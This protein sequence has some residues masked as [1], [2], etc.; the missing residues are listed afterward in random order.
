MFEK[1]GIK[2]FRILLA[3]GF[4]FVL[5]GIN[6]MIFSP[7]KKVEGFIS[8]LF[9]ILIVLSAGIIY[10]SILTKKSLLLYLGLNLFVYSICVS[11]IKCHD[12]DVTIL[13]VWPIMMISFGLTLIPCEYLKL[14]KIK[15][16]YIVPAIVLSVI[17]IVF[18]LFSFQVI[19]IPLA[20]F[21][22]IFWPVL[23]IVAGLILIV[24]YFYNSRTSEQSTDCLSE[25]VDE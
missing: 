23:M 3:I 8:I 15:T 25:S 4:L 18:M 24:Y 5:I 9:F 16:I 13:K 17:G 10:L 12:F 19:Q 11:I 14:K 22:S 7:T 6:F 21:F 1:K 2:F 20:K